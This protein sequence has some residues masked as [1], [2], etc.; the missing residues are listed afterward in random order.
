[1]NA[2]TARLP[3]DGS[4]LVIG[5]EAGLLGFSEAALDNLERRSV[6][7]GGFVAALEGCEPQR[8]IVLILGVEDSSSLPATIGCARQLLVEEGKLFCVFPGLQPGTPFFEHAVGALAEAGFCPLREEPADGLGGESWLEARKDGYR[9]RPYRDGDEEEILRLFNI[10]FTPP[11]SLDHWNWKYRRNPHGNL[12]ISTAK[13]RSG[14]LVAQY[15]AYPIRWRRA[16]PGHSATTLVCHQVGDTM[17]A[18]SHRHVGRGPTSLLSRTAR[19][20]YARFCAGEVAFNYGFNTG[21]IQRFSQLFVGAKKVWDIE[22]LS[23]AAERLRLPPEK[24]ALRVSRTCQLDSAFDELFERSAPA[25]GLLV[26][27]DQRYLRWRYLE[28]PDREYAFYRVDRNQDLVGWSV[29]RR[30]GDRLVWGD[31]LFDPEA[32]EA[33]QVLLDHA[34]GGGGESRPARVEAWFSSHPRWWSDLVTELGFQRHPEPQG[35]GMVYVPFLE[36]PGEEL[37]SGYYMSM[38]DSDLF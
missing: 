23:C 10:A 21:N 34:L 37:E 30:D 1:M 16:Q 18:A 32:P 38:G 17:T 11:R 31:A 29:F 20:F 36:S 28:C 22:I 7:E 12:R 8:A 15:C 33:V 35:L 24:S 14:E 13:T 26:E 5:G 19:H 2:L 27:R 3:T 6:G 9:I 25:F 4:T